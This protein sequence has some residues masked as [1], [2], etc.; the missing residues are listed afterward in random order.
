VGQSDRGPGPLAGPGLG[1]GTLAERQ[2]TQPSQ[3]GG[4]EPPAVQVEVPPS[5]ISGLVHGAG[6]FLRSRS[7]AHEDLSQRGFKVGSRAT[8]TKV[9]PSTVKAMANP[10][11][12]T[13]QVHMALK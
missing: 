9:K 11:G 8:P 2:G 7:Q 10:A 6:P 5:V 12:S 13:H 4:E 1:G 3:G